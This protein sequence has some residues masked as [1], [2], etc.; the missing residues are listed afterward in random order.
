MLT[1]PARAQMFDTGLAIFLPAIEAEEALD[2]IIYDWYSF[3]LD[4]SWSPEDSD[5]Y[6]MLEPIIR[7]H[8]ELDD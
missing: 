8:G 6:D 5:F 1:K 7:E 2:R 3:L 4:D